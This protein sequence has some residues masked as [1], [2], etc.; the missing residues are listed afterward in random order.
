MLPIE[1]LETAVLNNDLVQIQEL[2]YA[3]TNVNE[4]LED[5]HTLLMI[6]VSRGYFDAVRLLVNA[7]A[8]VNVISDQGD[9]ALALSIS[10][11]WEEIFNYLSPITSDDIRKWAE[12]SGLIGSATDGDP[13]I[14]EL[15]YSNGADLNAT[16]EE[17]EGKTALIIATEFRNIPFVKALI[18]AEA[19]VNL[20]DC[21]GQTPLIVATKFRN[22]TEAKMNGVEE[23]LLEL[24]QLLID[25]GAN[26]NA[27][28]N[29]GKTALI[30][31][32]ESG[33]IQCLKFLLEKGADID[34]KD[35]EGITALDYSKTK[36]KNEVSRLLQDAGAT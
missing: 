11:G 35:Y 33:T 19:D 22:P 31:T 26:L 27:I 4:P 34:I 8:D 36:G 12:L 20:R 1:S 32:C 21:E 7:G 2:I 15:L 14:V 24:I 6:A 9:N 25:A 30:Y 10:G 18:R 17:H 16:S 28:D 23:A 5:S 3:D 29:Y 13:R